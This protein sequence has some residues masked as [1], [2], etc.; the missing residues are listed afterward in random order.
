MRREWSVEFATFRP[1]GDDKDF[2][3]CVKEVEKIS[4]GGAP[5]ALAS[6]YLL[7]LSLLIHDPG[8]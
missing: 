3:V 4:R 8:M 7:A 1:R 6:H 2:V 5:F